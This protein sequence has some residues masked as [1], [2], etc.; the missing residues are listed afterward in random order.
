[1]KKSINFYN[2]EEVSL[3]SVMKYLLQIAV[4]TSSFLFFLEGSMA[5]TTIDTG[6]PW[7]DIYE[8][9]SPYTMLIRIQGLKKNGDNYQDSGSGIIV[10]DNGY[11]LTVNHLFPS[12]HDFE[13]DEYGIYGVINPQKSS[14]ILDELDLEILFQDPRHDLALLKFKRN[15]NR[16]SPIRISNTHK[17]KPAQHILVMGYP[18]GG[19]LRP[20]EGLISPYDVKPFFATT[21]RV[22]GGNSGG[23]I[24]DRS[25]D[26][27]GILDA[28]EQIMLHDLLGSD[29]LEALTSLFKNE[30]RIRESLK[31]GSGLVSMGLFIPIDIVMETIGKN[32]D[33]T[34]TTSGEPL[35]SRSIERIEFAYSFE[36]IKD[37]HP[38]VFAPHTKDNYEKYF[39]ALPGYKIVSAEVIKTSDSRASLEPLKI[40]PD[41]TKVT[42]SF[43]LTSGP[44]VDQY[45]GW[46]M[47]NI[48]TVQERRR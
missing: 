5:Q 38:V 8:A 3:M 1:M 46:L 9:T 48:V 41:G 40:S 44:L 27:V 34:S 43:A 2:Y 15:G 22:E 11:I 19:V 32:Y 33:L 31:E 42:L 26:L 18:K 21:A 4:F 14:E 24:F 13:G 25:G 23:P 47:G 10:G 17:L 30:G 12:K 35:P 36:Q 20:T 28:G 7:P 6:D 39:N 45:R 37:D 29:I 16:G